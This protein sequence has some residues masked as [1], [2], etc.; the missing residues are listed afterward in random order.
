MNDSIDETKKDKKR[1]NQKKIKK[2]QKS[3]LQKNSI[4][5][6]KREEILRINQERKEDQYKQVE[7]YLNESG[8]DIAFN[9]IFAELIS[10][11]ILPENFFLYTSKRLIEIGKEIEGMETNIPTYVD[12]PLP[13]G[14]EDLSLK[15]ENN[16]DK[17]I[18]SPK[19]NDVNKNIKKS[20]SKKKV[21][22]K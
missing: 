3:K 17:I 1:S 22:K 2:V 14:I 16:N 7:E 11:Q 12:K 4:T 13:E 5:Q 10:N 6:K 18:G 15:K 21:S 9:I 19:S 20:K 8:L